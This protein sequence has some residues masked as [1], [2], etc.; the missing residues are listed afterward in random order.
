MAAA[1][2]D[3][4]G[5]VSYTGLCRDSEL[6]PRSA[7]L[8]R[9]VHELLPAVESLRLDCVVAE[10]GSRTVYI[11]HTIKPAWMRLKRMVSAAGKR[12][13]AQVW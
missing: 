11:L 9:K 3:A 2:D 8:G 12:R 6:S 5:D 10:R 7:V 1:A 13:L 4:V